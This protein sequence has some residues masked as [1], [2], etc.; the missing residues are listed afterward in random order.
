MHHEKIKVNQSTLHLAARALYLI[1]FHARKR[2]RGW[3]GNFTA[4]NRG[5]RVP[6][7][8]ALSYPSWNIIIP[9]VSGKRKARELVLRRKHGVAKGLGVT[10]LVLRTHQ[11][12]GVRVARTTAVHGPWLHHT[13]P[14]PSRGWNDNLAGMTIPGRQHICLA[15]LALF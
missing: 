1:S 5:W 6:A 15:A 12:Q 4:A 14:A 7:H 10:V 8:S 9:T 3:E 13:C 11:Q 2:A